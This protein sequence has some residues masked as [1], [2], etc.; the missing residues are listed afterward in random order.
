MMMAGCVMMKCGYG[1]DE[2]SMQVQSR[3]DKKSK[4]TD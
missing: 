3:A 1:Y 4:T 2:V